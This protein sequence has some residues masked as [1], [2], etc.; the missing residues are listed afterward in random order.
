MRL[1]VFPLPSRMLILFLL[2]GFA[3]RHL[4]VRSCGLRDH[5]AAAR[6][7]WRW[8][9]PS[10]LP[11]WE[12]DT[13]YLSCEE[14]EDDLERR[15]QTLVPYFIR[16][17]ETYRQHKSPKRW[18]QARHLREGP[19]TD[20]LEISRL[21]DDLVKAHGQQNRVA[22]ESRPPG[23]TPLLIVVDGIHELLVTDRRDRSR[24]G[25]SRRLRSLVENSTAHRGARNHYVRRL[26]RP[27]CIRFGLCCGSG[28][29]HRFR[30]DG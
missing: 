9:F 29:G 6:H 26:Q 12:F 14:N 2:E 7:R 8:D 3:S 17:T 13:I 25:E 30:E 21:V 16:R 11:R 22:V 4:K 19:D 23:L 27:S 18:F 15:I 24:E 5:P 1:T 10:R 28:R 20:Y